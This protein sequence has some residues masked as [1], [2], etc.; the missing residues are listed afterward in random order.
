MVLYD[1]LRNTDSDYTFGI[2]KLF[3]STIV[4][5]PQS[6]WFEPAYMYYIMYGEY[7][8]LSRIC[9]TFIPDNILT[10]QEYAQHE[11]S[12]CLQFASSCVQPWSF[13]WVRV[14]QVRSTLVIWLGPCCSAAFNP[15][16]LVGS[17]L[18][19]F[20]LFCVAW[21]YSMCLRSVSC[22]QCF[23]SFCVVHSWL[24]LQF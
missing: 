23:L 24:S 17:V 5:T 10:W 18:F 22:V 8:H 6:I 20:S 21:F 12:N 2:F 19:R 9:I 11:G 4:I 15:G 16:H 1:F 14:V 13:G 7:L 3:L